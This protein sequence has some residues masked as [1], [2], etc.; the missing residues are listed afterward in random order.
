MG[1]PP[2][3]EYRP[4]TKKRSCLHLKWGAGNVPFPV[5]WGVLS[6]L[7]RAARENAPPKRGR[8]MSLVRSGGLACIVVK[9]L[10]LRLSSFRN[11]PTDT[12][13]AK[14]CDKVSEHLPKH[15]GLVI[16]EKQPR[17]CGNGYDTTDQKPPAESATTRCLIPILLNERA[18]LIARQLFEQRIRSRTNMKA[19]PHLSPTTCSPSLVAGRLL[20]L[21]WEW[22]R[23]AIVRFRNIPGV[24]HFVSSPVDSSSWRVSR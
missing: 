1:F 5:S 24:A 18:D 22:L 16:R 6:G 8:S 7:S 15:R 12:C 9:Q 13:S 20:V 3:C 19:K 11:P 10:Q 14:K 23:F 2:W 17:E 21:T 4:E